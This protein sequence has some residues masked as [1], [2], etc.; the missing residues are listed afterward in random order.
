MRGGLLQIL[1]NLENA[2]HCG[3]KDLYDL[4]DP[5]S[6]GTMIRNVFLN[7][8]SDSLRILVNRLRNELSNRS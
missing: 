5:F 7:D 4:A 2:T 8:F 3:E 1:S 6:Q